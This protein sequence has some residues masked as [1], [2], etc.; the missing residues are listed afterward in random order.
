MNTSALIQR[1]QDAGLELRLVNG[2]IKVTGKRSA[3]AA[4]IEPLRQHKQDLIRW[5][6]S[7]NDPEPPADPSQ[8]RELATAYH[9][10]HFK[11]RICCAAGQGVGRRCTT[12]MALWTSY[13]DTVSKTS[14]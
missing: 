9:D 1:A 10:H 14:T 11:C 5:F 3:V 4:L 2:K 13:C 7:A 12:G 6:T 8:W